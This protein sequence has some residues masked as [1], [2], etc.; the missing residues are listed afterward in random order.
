MIPL[1]DFRVK[2]RHGCGPAV[3]FIVFDKV[4]QA[5]AWYRR[6]RPGHWSTDSKHGH[7]RGWVARFVSTTNG[8]RCERW[9]ILA[10]SRGGAGTVAHECFHAAIDW[11]RTHRWKSINSRREERLA[12][13]VDGLCRS[14]WSMF[15]RLKLDRYRKPGVRA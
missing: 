13:I 7:G 15:Y 8:D 4:P 9:I 1:A 6:Q 3:R 10:L 2:F 11:A 12:S 14:Y 5:Q